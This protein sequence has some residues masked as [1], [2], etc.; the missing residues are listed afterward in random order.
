[1]GEKSELSFH[2]LGAFN[3]FY[4]QILMDILYILVI[5][6]NFGGTISH[7]KSHKCSSLACS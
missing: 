7:K 4:I 1:M 2:L 3:Y 6:Y 5:Y